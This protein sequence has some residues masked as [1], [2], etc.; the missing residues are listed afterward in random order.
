MNMFSYDVNY[1]L[2]DKTPSAEEMAEILKAFLQTLFTSFNNSQFKF[3]DDLCD[4]SSEKNKEFMTLYQQ[5][6]K[7][8]GIKKLVQLEYFRIL[9]DIFV[10]EHVFNYYII[11]TKELINTAADKKLFNNLNELFSDFPFR[12]IYQIFI[13]K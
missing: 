9:L 8:I 10:N 5:M 3:L 2:D 13:A 4:Y 6:Q 7:R 1:P 11:N 12:N